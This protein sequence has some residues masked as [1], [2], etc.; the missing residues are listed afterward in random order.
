MTNQLR[1][2]EQRLARWVVYGV[3][4]APLVAILSGNLGL[5]AITPWIIY[6][7]IAVLMIVMLSHREIDVDPLI[8]WFLY[9]TIALTPI[10]PNGRRLPVPARS[11]THQPT[12]RR[13]FAC[14]K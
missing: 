13:L 11:V 7:S 9:T 1:C 10:L 2:A 12:C 14:L 3:L 4:A 5:G 8:G 6:A